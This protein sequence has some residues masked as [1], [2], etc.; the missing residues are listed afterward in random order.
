[1]TLSSAKTDKIDSHLPIS[2]G[3]WISCFCLSSLLVIYGGVI[4]WHFYTQSKKHALLELNPAK[5]IYHPPTGGSFAVFYRGIRFNTPFQAGVLEMPFSYR[6]DHELGPDFP[7]ENTSGRFMARLKVPETAR[8][9]FF[10]DANDGAKIWIDNKLIFDK[11]DTVS[12]HEYTV[13]L[14]LKRGT[15][16]LYA[17]WYNKEN[18]GWFGIW[19]SSDKMTRRF[20]APE[21]LIP[22][23]GVTAPK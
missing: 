13:D 1:M 18:N 19:W 15:V 6:T 12:I 4:S 17:E 7:P 10:V 9:S 11:E 20:L 23:P 2:R 8:Y 16:P 22:D 5:E 14:D 3:V 21:N